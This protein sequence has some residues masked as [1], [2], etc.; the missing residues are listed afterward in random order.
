MFSIKKR[1]IDYLRS[2]V[3]QTDFV[4]VSSYG[5]YNERLSEKEKKFRVHLIITACKL[6]FRISQ[7]KI[8][9]VL[10]FGHEQWGTPYLFNKILVFMIMIN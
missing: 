4:S 1:R 5:S 3:Y 9:Y 8:E 10:T 2:T 7:K 6:Y